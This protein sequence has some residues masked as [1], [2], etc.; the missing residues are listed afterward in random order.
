M[1]NLRTSGSSLGTAVVTGASAGIGKV[2]ADRLAQRGFDLVLVARRGDKLETIAAAI[3]KTHD[4]AVE[5]IVADL[6]KVADLERIAALVGSSD[7]RVTMLVNNAGTSKMASVADTGL[8]AT[9]AMTDLNV[10]ALV[11]LSLAALTAF[12]ARDHGTIVNIGSILGFH[13]L[14][15]SS[16]Y[17][18]T[19]GY[20][21]NF[22]RGLQD[23]TQGTGVKVQLVLPASTAT[24]L[25]E[26]AGVPISHLD[27]ASVMTVEDC[28][29]AAMA[30]LDL[31]ERITF[32]SV[33]SAGELLATYDAA[34]MALLGASQTGRPASRYLLPS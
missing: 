31:G 7:P 26:I 8:T 14:P 17:S 28:V 9:T 24:D 3:R 5:T 13:S 22:T 4:V 2:Y 19:K 12:K 27:P 11:S 6:G 1:T 34:R 10:T 33:E 16:V 20:V 32:P 29:D 30:G 25:W 18:A 21:L 15:I 23:E